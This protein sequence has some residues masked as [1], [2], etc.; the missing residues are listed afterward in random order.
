MD[1]G[2]LRCPGCGAPAGADLLRCPHCASRLATVA[3]PSCF[4]MVFRG[5]RHCPHCGARAQRE[6]RGEPAALSCPECRAELAALEVGGTRLAECGACSGLWLGNGCLEALLADRERQ[7]AV[8]AFRP[9]PPP[10]GVAPVERVRYRPCAAC[11]VLMNRAN[12]QRI[13][14]VIVD[15]CRDHGTWFDRDELR[16]V[17]EF[18]RAGGLDRA[19]AREKDAL[20]EERRRLELARAD[21]LRARAGSGADREA[22][23]LRWDLSDA[24]SALLGLVR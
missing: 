5:T 9:P 21:V 19:R 8:L 14:G 18:V 22:E 1:A 11:G 4:G 6:E 13:S 3:C 10:E 23:P 20:A 24:L 17:V 12:F 2:T 16:R 7:A 15:A